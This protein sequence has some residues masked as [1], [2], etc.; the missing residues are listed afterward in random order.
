MRSVDIPRK[1]LISIFVGIVCLWVFVANVIKLVSFYHPLDMDELSE[2]NMKVGRYVQGTISECVVVPV[3]HRQDM[4]SGWDSEFLGAGG[5][6][7]YSYTVPISE[8][9]FVRVWLYDKESVDML[10]R[11]V[12]GD[13]VEFSFSGIIQEGGP[14]STEWYGWDPDF[15]QSKVV[16]EY[17]IWQKSMEAETNLCFMGVLG[18]I[19]AAWAYYSCDG[20]RILEV[21]KKPDPHVKFKYNYNKENELIIAKKRLEKYKEWEK[22]YRKNKKVGTVCGIAGFL[23]ML[24]TNFKWIGLLLMI[25]GIKKWWDFFINSENKYAVKVAK[26]FS[27]KTLQT[28]RAEEEMKIEILENSVEICDNSNRVLNE[29]THND[30]R[31]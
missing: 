28:K 13:T 18:M 1:A 14:I 8:G 11:F 19:L 5:R 12:C 27:I 16:A 21:S 3:F 29:G 31:T 20:I 2:Q 30:D 17:E 23:M 26:L 10:E 15:D 4:L 9:Q 25:Y 7:Y 22:E 6:R 24:W